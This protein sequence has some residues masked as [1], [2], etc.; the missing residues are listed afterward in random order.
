MDLQNVGMRT[1]DL[2]NSSNIY[3][4]DPKDKSFNDS[5]LLYDGI[6]EIEGGKRLSK[7]KKMQIRLSDIIIFTDKLSTSGSDTEKIRAKTLSDKNS[8]K[9]S[10]VKIITR[11]CGDAFFIIQGSF[12]GLFKNKSQQRFLPLTKPSV[13]EVLRTGAD[14]SVKEVDVGTSF[15]GLSTNH[16]ESCSMGT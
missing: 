15:I 14:W 6:I 13:K 7:F 5:I 1:L 4:K 12:Y 10:Q 11:M 8:E 3:W 9:E 2:L 16:I